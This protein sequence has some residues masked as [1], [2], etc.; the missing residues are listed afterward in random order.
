[1]MRTQTCGLRIASVQRIGAGAGGKNAKSKSSAVSGV[2]ALHHAALS[3]SRRSQRVPRRR[4]AAARTDPV[5]CEPYCLRDERFGVAVQRF[6]ANRSGE[7]C[8]S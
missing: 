3:D 5:C 8:Q 6:I 2:I 4:R 7:H 1:M